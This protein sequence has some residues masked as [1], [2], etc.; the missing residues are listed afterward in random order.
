[1]NRQIAETLTLRAGPEARARIATDGVSADAFATL[2][3]ASG[4]PKWLILAGL[5]RQLMGDFFRDRNAPLALLGTSVGTWRHAMFAQRD[6]LSALDRF[7]AAYLAQ[8]YSAQPTVAELTAA[9][10]RLLGILLGEHGAR[11]IVDN[12][13]FHT[14]I[15]AARCRGY[16]A[17]EAR[18][19]LLSALALAAVLNI[20]SRRSLALHFERILFASGDRSA[21]QLRGLPARET[22]LTQDNVVDALLATAAVPMVFAPRRDIAGAPPGVY[23]DGGITDYHFD[24]DIDA[25]PGLVLYPHFYPHITPGWFD[26]LLRWRSPRGAL[27]NRTLLVA[28]S[29]AFVAALPGGAVPDRRDFARYD[30]LTRERFWR[31]AVDESRRLGDAF[32]AWCR[33]PEPARYLQPL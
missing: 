21:L 10:E 27:R 17:H 19:P 29:P 28:P 18:G 24:L 9:A 5:D 11:D 31:A 30:D 6:P 20:V 25:P 23:R 32:A 15:V 14:H 26:K 13:V 16:A 2:L 12:R 8:R 7:L 33:D 22:A 3:G 1:M 4:G